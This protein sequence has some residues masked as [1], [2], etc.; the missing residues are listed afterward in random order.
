MVLGQ[1]PGAG[2]E[3]RRGAKVALTVSRGPAPV[4][5]P[6]LSGLTDKE[7]KSALEQGRA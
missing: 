1:D 2:E 5:V 6:S 4:D 7:A 3:L